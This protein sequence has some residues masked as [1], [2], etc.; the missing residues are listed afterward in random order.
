MVAAV[1][2][3]GSTLRKLSCTSAICWEFMAVSGFVFVCLRVEMRK[4]GDRRAHAALDH[5]QAALEVGVVDGGREV[6][7]LAIGPAHR[8]ERAAER[9]AEPGEEGFLRVLRVHGVAP[10]CLLTRRAIATAVPVPFSCR[11]SMG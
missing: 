4:G 8:I 9:A 7:E 10:F 1:S 3:M 11:G 6:L 2:E 5:A